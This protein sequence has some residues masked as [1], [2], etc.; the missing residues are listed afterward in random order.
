MVSEKEGMKESINKADVLKMKF[1]ILTRKEKL[2]FL[3]R[4]AEFIY[5]DEE[6]KDADQVPRM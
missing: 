1:S 2:E 6:I 5:G 3:K 4:L